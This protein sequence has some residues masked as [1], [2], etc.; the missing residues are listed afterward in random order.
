MAIAMAARRI[1]KWLLGGVVALLG[2]IALAIYQG[3]L[4]GITDATKPLA[5]RTV[6]SVLNWVDDTFPP[7]L[8]QADKNAALAI[9]MA[10]LEGD[11]DGSQ[12]RYV[13]QSLVR[14]LDLTG[15]GRQIQVLEAG[16]MLKLGTARDLWRQREAAEVMGRAWL[17]QSGAGLLIWGEVAGRDK[18]LR[19]NFLP[20]EGKTAIRT[21][22]SYLLTDR[23][24]LSSDFGEDLGIVIVARVA[25][26]LARAL[27]YNQLIPDLLE[28]IYPR[29]TAIS[30]NPAVAQSKASCDLKLTSA[31][32]LMVLGDVRDHTD[33]V[34]Q[35]IA[36]SQSLIANDRCAVNRHTVATAN[37][38][39][40][41][42]LLVLG[43]RERGTARLEEAITALGAAFKDLTR[44]QTPFE[45]AATR[46]F[47]G[48]TLTELARREGSIPR[49]EEAISATREALKELNRER[50]PLIW[51]GAQ[52]SLGT[53]LT[54]LGM[55]KRSAAQLE[56]AITAF[57]EALKEQKREREPLIWAG[58]QFGL[59]IA[60]M[61]LGIRHSAAQ[62]EEAITAFREA[63]KE[64]KREREPLIWALTQS[65][66]GMALTARAIH[67]SG[68][69]RFEEA[70]TAFREALKEQKREREPLIWVDTQ[71][72]LGLALRFLGARAR[73]T[74]W[75]EQAVDAYRTALEVAEAAGA[76]SHTLDSFRSGLIE[77][78]KELENQRPK[79]N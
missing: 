72:S 21:N 20:S 25:A 37:V 8:P 60:L 35:A 64:R 49:F 18:V 77:A 19:I 51:A 53:A 75:L 67:E 30:A 2:A 57:R 9:L 34:N 28:E 39:L 17:K 7:R 58:T 76:D 1:T 42:S 78:E 40:A 26:P 3:L 46:A 15:K 23:F 79:K 65:K 12:S 50:E 62:L 4:G 59:G 33:Q 70:I 14:A 63:L 68:T 74:T 11:G 29:L 41:S 56:Q 47:L 66:L 16:R 54:E 73:N 31:M 48:F 10:Q 38:V 61:D 6:N 36:I 44:E 22:E 5:S 71:A 69:A 55:R 32:V 27:V 24:E 13:H 45:W 43:K 52:F